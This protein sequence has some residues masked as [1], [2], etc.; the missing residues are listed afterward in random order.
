[1]IFKLMEIQPE[2]CLAIRE[3]NAN[4]ILNKRQPKIQQLT[5]RRLWNGLRFTR[6]FDLFFLKELNSSRW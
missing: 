2:S 6:L 3:K 1:M 4:R 5:W